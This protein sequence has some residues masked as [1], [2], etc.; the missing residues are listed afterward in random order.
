MKYAMLSDGVESIGNM[1]FSGCSALEG[2]S[3][4]RGVQSFGSDIIKDSESTVIY[5]FRDSAAASALKGYDVSYLMGDVDNDGRMT[6]IDATRVQRMLAGMIG[7]NA[8]GMCVSD[9]DSDAD[10]SVFDVTRIQR[11]LAGFA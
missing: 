4:S 1:A 8:R 3:I 5:C 9:M 7:L 11:L 6:I 10:V 2:I